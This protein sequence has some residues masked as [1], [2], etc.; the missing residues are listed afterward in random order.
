M[1]EKTG[2]ELVALFED[3]AKNHTLILQYALPK[4]KEI[5][6]TYRKAKKELLEYIKKLENNQAPS[7]SSTVT[8]RLF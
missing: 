7:E 8:Y 5:E 2:E 3:A 6:V 4:E 1:K